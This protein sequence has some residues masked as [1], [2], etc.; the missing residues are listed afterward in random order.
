MVPGG[1]ANMVPGGAA[2]IHSFRVYFHIFST[3]FEC[4]IYHN[5]L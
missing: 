5:E 2:N 4:S 1:T 3:L